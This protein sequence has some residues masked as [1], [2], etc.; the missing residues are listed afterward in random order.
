MSKKLLSPK[1]GAVQ[2]NCEFD[3]FAEFSFA[4][5]QHGP[6]KS[7]CIAGYFRINQFKRYQ[8]QLRPFFETLVP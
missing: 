6:Q 1:A 7:Y 2:S 8:F 5:T 3:A 4:Y